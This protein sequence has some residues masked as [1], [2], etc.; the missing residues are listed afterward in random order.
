MHHNEY[1]SIA[2][3][4]RAARTLGNQHWRQHIACSG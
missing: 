4:V 2:L 3:N 1:V